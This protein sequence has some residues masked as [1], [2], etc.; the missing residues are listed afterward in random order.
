MENNNG[1]IKARMFVGGLKSLFIDM[2]ETLDQVEKTGS[3]PVDILQSLVDIKSAIDMTLIQLSK[4]Q[5]RCCEHSPVCSHD[6]ECKIC[7]EGEETCECDFSGNEYDDEELIEK[8]EEVRPVKKPKVKVV[9]S[10]LK[11]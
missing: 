10:K 8:E 2:A 7:G 5:M 3:M 4:T 6:E 9:K 1:A 11:H